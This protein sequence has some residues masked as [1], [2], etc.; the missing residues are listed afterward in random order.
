MAT[1]EEIGIRQR[2]KG[3][4]IAYQTSRGWSQREMADFLQISLKNYEGYLKP[5]RGVP[6]GIIAR[7]CNFTNTDVNWIMGTQKVRATA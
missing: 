7:F 5:E 6:V 3:A 1:K 4:M 2:I